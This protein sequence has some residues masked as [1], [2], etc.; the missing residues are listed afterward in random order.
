MAVAISKNGVPIRLPLERW[1]HI[2]ESHDELAGR[3]SD[4]LET[5]AEPGVVIRGYAGEFL[6][7]RRVEG[8]KALI[9]V[10][11]E[12]AAQDGFVITAYLTSR[13]KSLMKRG[14][15]WQKE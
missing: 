13:L 15:I 10:Y 4:V 12:R 8:G 7:A 1:F 11:R 2:E 3:Y 9:V 5:V 6:A 14:V